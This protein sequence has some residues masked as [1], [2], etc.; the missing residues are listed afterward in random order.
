M[1]R[2][3][4]WRRAARAEARVTMRASQNPLTRDAMV[5]SAAARAWAD[6]VL[7]VSRK[8]D[9][10]EVVVSVAIAPLVEEPE[11][12]HFDGATYDPALDH[13]R[14]SK[15]LGRVFVVMADGEWR[16]LEAIQRRIRQLISLTC[17][18]SQAGIS[19]RLRDLRKRR[20]G[21]YP[22][23]SRRNPNNSGLWEYRLAGK[24]RKTNLEDGHE[25]A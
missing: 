7:R 15:Q 19:A 10:T 14:L 25:S 24:V 1:S 12:P 5:A 9:D 17:R 6:A 22:V 11:R 8:W 23:E 13:E 16:S 4:D 3:A 18:D 20:F 2:R 21:A